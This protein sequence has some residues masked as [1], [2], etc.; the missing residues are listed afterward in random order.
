VT[1][2]VR[3]TWW[4]VLLGVLRSVLGLWLLVYVLK[5][6]GAW[7]ALPALFARPWLLVLLNVVPIAG[8]AV[9]AGRLSVLCGAQGMALPFTTGFRVVSIGALFGLWIPG[10]TGGD[11]MK[12]YYL[13]RLHPSRT[14]EIATVLL[15]D[16]VVALFAL[17]VLL[18]GLLALQP[19]LLA[20]PAIKAAAIVVGLSTIALMAG[21]RVVGSVWFRENRRFRGVLRR[22]PLGGHLSRAAD[23]AHGFRGR[24]GALA[25]A[26]GMSLAGHAL[27]AVTLA[28]VA[29]VLLPGMSPLAASSLALLGLIANVLPITPGGLGVGEA[30]ADALFRLVGVSGGAALVTAWRAGMLAISAAGALFYAH[31][32]RRRQVVS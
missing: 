22:L 10:G 4:R 32:V 20:V 27:L 25:A 9:E 3:P 5:A 16:R 24:T 6:G 21:A 11:V 14:V 15:V 12:L 17:L 2:R 7:E 30:A 28:V 13:A 18:L 29:A 31:G 8:A 19:A 23:A 1:A 26:A